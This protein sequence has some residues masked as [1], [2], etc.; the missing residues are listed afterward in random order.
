MAYFSIFCLTV[1]CSRFVPSILPMSLKTR[2]YYQGYSG[3]II[4]FF[5]SL[6]LFLFPIIWGKKDL[7]IS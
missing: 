1:F 7:F 2:L 3:L 4:G 6:P 5:I